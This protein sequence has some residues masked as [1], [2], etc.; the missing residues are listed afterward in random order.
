MHWSLKCLP[1]EVMQTVILLP[2]NFPPSPLPSPPLPLPLY[3]SPLQRMDSMG[4][5]M[6]Q[7]NLYLKLFKLVFGSVT[8][9]AQENEL[10][11]KV[12]FLLKKYSIATILMK[13]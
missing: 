11:L 9:F 2:Y 5:N 6:D 7:S 4:D 12:S 3:P 13:N 1:P 8:L 10:M